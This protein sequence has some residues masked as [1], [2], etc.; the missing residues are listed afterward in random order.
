MYPDRE[1]DTSHRFVIMNPMLLKFFPLANLAVVFIL[2][3]SSCTSEEPANQEEQAVSVTTSEAIYRDLSHTFRTSSTVVPYQ[4]VFVA[5]QISGLVEEVH[6]EEGDVV[7][8]GDLMAKIDTRLQ[9]TD[10]RKARVALDEAER[11]YQRSAQLFD[12][13]AISEADYLNDRSTYELAQSEVEQ[14]ELLIEYGRIKAPVD[15]VVTSR[16]V[17]IGNSVSENEQLFQI[18]DLNNLVVRPGVSEMDLTGLETGQTLEV[19][20][21]VYPG[22]TFEGRIRRIFPESDA[23]SRL[24]TVEVQLDQEAAGRVIRPG[25]LARIRFVTDRQE[26]SLAV[27]TEA[28]AE[29]NGETVV[30]V[31]N[32]Q[33]DTVAMNHV[34]IGIR[35]DGHAQILSGLDDEDTVAAANLDALEDGTRVRVVGRFRRSGFRE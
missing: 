21:D 19:T 2:A 18:A 23:E 13:E 34:E 22:E 7:Q 11:N 1:S 3:I 26:Q 12:R 14:L 5:S 9:Q 20:L 15:A 24:F 33:N 29:R 4:R 27:P 10:L 32:E 28:L 31:L 6:F 8:Q 17:E 35:R 16:D 30:F 25:Y